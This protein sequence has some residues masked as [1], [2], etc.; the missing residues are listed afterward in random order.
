MNTKNTTKKITEIT[1]ND[2]DNVRAVA[3]D[4]IKAFGL[5]KADQLACAIL[6][7]S[8]MN[9]WVE[10]RECVE[11]AGGMEPVAA[12]RTVC[13]FI[14]RNYVCW[15][16]EETNTDL[17]DDHRALR[18][19][20]IEIRLAPTAEAT[21]RWDNKVSYA[22][23]DEV[24]LLAYGLYSD[25]RTGLAASEYNLAAAGMI[26]M[27]GGHV[28]GVMRDGDNG[29]GD[30]RWTLTD[31]GQRASSAELEAIMLRDPPLDIARSD[32]K[33]EAEDVAD[34]CGDEDDDSPILAMHRRIAD[35]LAKRA[36]RIANELGGSR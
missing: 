2:K 31:R 15:R 29:W 3:N 10:L 24:F 19:R 18:E 23:D 28:V 27:I 4:I 8:L 22:R 20:A 16:S 6:S 12:A 17:N 14:H 21:A 35:F 26:E 13:D 9:F 25:A 7:R 30:L 34:N 5:H 1:F 11:L 33:D 32:A 36:D